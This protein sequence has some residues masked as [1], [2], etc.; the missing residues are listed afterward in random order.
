[1]GESFEKIVEET[2]HKPDFDYKEVE[3]IFLEPHV[4]EKYKV[5]FKLPQHEKVKE[6]LCEKHDFSKD[7]VE[8]ALKKLEAVINEKGRQSKLS[9]WT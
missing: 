4:D 2:G 8:N 9:S 1:M 7:R 3:K 5:E 6:F